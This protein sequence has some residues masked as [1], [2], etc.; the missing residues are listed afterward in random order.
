MIDGYIYLI[1]SEA[2]DAGKVGWSRTYPSDRLVKAQTS[3]PDLLVLDIVVQGGRPVEGVLHALLRDRHVRGEWFRG[4]DFLCPLFGMLQ[5]ATIN[6]D[7]EDI[8]LTVD[9]AQRCYLQAAAGPI[10]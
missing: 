10:A 8:P 5:E 1:T 6:S 7:D 3:N 2:Q 4:L 9:E